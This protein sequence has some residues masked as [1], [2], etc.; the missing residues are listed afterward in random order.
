M[1]RILE[2][3]AAVVSTT[4]ALLAAIAVPTVVML[5]GAT[6]ICISMDQI[7]LI[8]PANP[9]DA[10]WFGF[11][12]ILA[13]A[14]G[15]SLTH[16]AAAMAKDVFRMLFGKPSAGQSKPSDK[17]TPQVEVVAAPAKDYW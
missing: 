2:L 14:T 7:T 13:V 12:T 17:Q 3:I 10:M 6:L 16:V 8:R 15:I 1:V 11:K 9:D 4:A 5:A